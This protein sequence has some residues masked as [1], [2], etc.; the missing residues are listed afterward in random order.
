MVKDLIGTPSLDVHGHQMNNVQ[1]NPA[2]KVTTKSALVQIKGRLVHRKLVEEHSMSEEAM[3]R[4]ICC[5]KMRR[6]NSNEGEYP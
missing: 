4:V 1:V 5:Q 3:E 6:R 2:L